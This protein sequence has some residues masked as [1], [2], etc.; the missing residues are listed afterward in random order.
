METQECIVPSI[1]RALPES[2]GSRT[3][4]MRELQRHAQVHQREP[5]ASERFA[6]AP[7]KQF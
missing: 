2:P 6:A 7:P 3:E 1:G 4:A 5:L